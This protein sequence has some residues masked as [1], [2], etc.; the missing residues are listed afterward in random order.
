[1]NNKLDMTWKKMAIATFRPLFRIRIDG[2]M[3]KKHEN[4]R[5]AN[6]Q[7]DICTRYSQK[8]KYLPIQTVG[9]YR[10]I[11][12]FIYEV[13][14]YAVNC[15]IRMLAT[16]KTTS[17]LQTG[18]KSR[19]SDDGLIYVTVLP[20]LKNEILWECVVVEIFISSKY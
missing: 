20:S 6:F 5:I 19:T 18:N 9:S 16:K 8:T 4:L 11:D 17:E 7:F 10:L 3:K 14:K 12:F 15:S 13:F 1:V 2:L